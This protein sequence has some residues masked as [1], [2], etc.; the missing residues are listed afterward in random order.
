MPSGA[1]TDCL[2]ASTNGRN[3]SIRFENIERHSCTGVHDGSSIRQ[4]QTQP[5]VQTTL[6]CSIVRVLMQGGPHLL[7]Q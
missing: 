3:D 1:L 4:T 5:D 2:P 7:F 6:Y